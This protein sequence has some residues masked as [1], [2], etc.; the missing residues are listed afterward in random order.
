MGVR[1]VLAISGSL[2][3]SSKTVTLVE[4][5]LR[6]LGSRGIETRHMIARELDATALLRGDVDHASLRTFV[7]AVRDAH[8]LIVATPIYKASFTGLLKAA[9]D[10][11][12]Q[13]AFAGKVVMPLGTGGS[14]AHVLALDYSLRPVIQSMGARHIVQSHFVAERDFQK[15]EPLVT[16]GDP[17]WAGLRHAT[18]NFLYSLTDDE[19]ATMLGHPHPA[20]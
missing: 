20:A 6:D 8:G 7:D 18:A 1:K 19:G 13:F 17:R 14:I 3:P 15:D 10:L 11:L 9:L 4:A 5:V 12:P 16:L 2:S